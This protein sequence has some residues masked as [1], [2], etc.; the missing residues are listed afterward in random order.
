[1]G[2]KI[3]NSGSSKE[4]GRSFVTV[5]NKY[6]HFTGEAFFNDND[7]PDTFSAFAGERYAEIRAGAKFAKFKYQQERLKLKTIQDLKKDI[8]NTIGFENIDKLVQRRIN[9]KLRDYSQSMEDYR[10]LYE[11]LNSSIA[12]Q[13]EEREKILSRSSKIK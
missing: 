12:K 5:Q 9:L 10:N 1:M 8:E 3:V 2:H 6:G 7:D 13:V 11:Y 4:Y